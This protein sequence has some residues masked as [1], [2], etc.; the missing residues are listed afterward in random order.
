[1]LKHYQYDCHE[2]QKGEHR[3]RFE[4]FYKLFMQTNQPTRTKPEKHIYCTRICSVK[5]QN[6]LEQD[7]TLNVCDSQLFQGVWKIVANSYAEPEV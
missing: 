3:C 7:F 1:M 2:G 4:S 6:R 5:S